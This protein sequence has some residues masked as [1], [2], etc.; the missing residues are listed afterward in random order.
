MR[1]KIGEMLITGLGEF[2]QLMET[3]VVDRMTY[4]M[5]CKDMAMDRRYSIHVTDTKI[6]NKV[7]GFVCR[8]CYNKFI[9][10][11]ANRGF[12]RVASLRTWAKHRK[13]SMRRT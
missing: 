7:E 1:G 2:S 12:F 8:H 5:I 13:D 9:D 6:A 11:H 4:C 3:G 10:S